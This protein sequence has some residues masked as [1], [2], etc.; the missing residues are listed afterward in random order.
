MLLKSSILSSTSFR[1]DN[2]FWRVE[3]AAVE[4][5]W[6]K[7]N[8]VAHGDGKNSA[9]GADPRIPPNKKQEGLPQ[10]SLASKKSSSPDN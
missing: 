5:L 6:R 4:Q 9:L 2:T 3:S 7:A 8:M 1:M 10:Q